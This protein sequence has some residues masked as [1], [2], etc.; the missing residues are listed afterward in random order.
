[1]GKREADFAHTHGGDDLSL[2][3]KLALET[4]SEVGDASFSISSNIGDLADVVE[5]VAADEEEDD[6]HASR[7]PQIAELDERKYIWR[8]GDCDSDSTGDE[9]KGGCPFHVIDG[10]L[11]LWVRPAGEATNKPSLD[12][13]GITQTRIEETCPSAQTL[14]SF[15]LSFL[16]YYSP[17]GRVMSDRFG[18][19][20]SVRASSRTEK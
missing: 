1:M 3:P 16:S 10:T 7:S 8:S 6:N 18:R 2:K 12:G 13:L 11:E 19:R 15:P 17:H 4:T 5:H 9:S 14:L 20:N